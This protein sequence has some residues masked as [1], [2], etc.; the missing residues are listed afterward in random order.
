MTSF[1]LSL[2]A[3]GSVIGGVVEVAPGQCRVDVVSNQGELSRLYVP[4]EKAI[5]D[6]K[7]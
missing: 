4:C 6:Y 1:I 2:V 5:K 7:R 3:A